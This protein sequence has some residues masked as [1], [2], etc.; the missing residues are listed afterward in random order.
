MPEIFIYI[1]DWCL[2]MVVVLSLDYLLHIAIKK[3][4]LRGEEP[5][6]FNFHFSSIYQRLTDENSTFELKNTWM[7]STE[8]VSY[9]ITSDFVCTTV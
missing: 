3:L 5:D 1:C 9:K 6:N 8:F 7:I 4:F 2:F